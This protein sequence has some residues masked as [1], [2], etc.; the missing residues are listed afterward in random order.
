MNDWSPRVLVIGW[1]GADW[2]LLRPLMAQGHLPNLAALV[3][4]ASHGELLSTLPPVTAA[5]WSSFITGRPPSHHGLLSW[6]LPLDGRLERAW[7]SAS[8]LHGP[9][10]WQLLSAA[11]RRLGVL[12]VP[13]TYPP[14]AL[15]G[16]LIA[17]M[18]TPSIASQFTYPPALRAA[19]LTEI[20]GYIPDVEMQRTERDT[21]SA[22]GVRRFLAEVEAALDHRARALDFLWRRGPFDF[23]MAVFETPD[24]LQHALYQFVAG[25]PT[26]SRPDW[27][28]V[29]RA[30]VGLYTRCDA[31]LGTL[32]ARAGAETTIVLLSDHGFG[33]L[34]SVWHLNEWLAAEGYLAWAETSSV[35]SPQPGRPAALT[36]AAGVRRLLG[37]LRRWLPQGW[38]QRS[39][40]TFAPLKQVNW[41]ATVAYAGLPTEEGLWLNVRGREPFGVVAPAAAYE[42]LRDELIRAAQA[43]T[44]PHTG[45][46]IVRRAC[47]REEIH[48]GPFA[49][50]APDILLELEEGYKVTPARSRAGLVQDVSSQGR[51]IHRRQGIVALAGPSIAPGPLTGATLPDL[52]PVI[53]AAAE[54]PAKGSISPLPS[55]GRGAGGDRSEPFTAEEAALLEARLA[56]LGYL[57]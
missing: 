32:L 45:R 10:L 29:R 33:P 2:R 3:A 49:G 53:L 44:D 31:L 7:V 28:A 14:P 41:P 56:A 50:R 39:R 1:D 24:R 57:E 8:A 9:T 12:N 6:Q 55:Q 25:R 35:F 15:N 22:A 26:E 38:V 30:V 43:F 17:G 36:S 16:E 37:P 47:R 54:K 34:R 23:F 18:L 20:P 52:L 5:A 19:L 13:L 4:R 21:R 46:P 11:G 51:G 27:D 48:D 42:L 40:V